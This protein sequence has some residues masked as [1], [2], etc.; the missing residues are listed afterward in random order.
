MR[1][2]KHLIATLVFVGIASLS[3]EYSKADETVVFNAWNFM[4]LS[5]PYTPIGAYCFPMLV[6]KDGKPSRAPEKYEPS[7]SYIP[8]EPTVRDFWK[9]YCSSGKKYDLYYAHP[10]VSSR[11]VSS[12]QKAIIEFSE[13]FKG[14][15]GMSDEE[16][17]IET[18]V[19]AFDID[20]DGKLES[21][22]QY[23]AGDSSQLRIYKFSGKDWT[24]WLEL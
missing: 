19:G 10:N 2:G 13:K 6:I 9:T 12:Q 23:S 3:G 22:T 20:H 16:G 11:S 18:F 7:G 17:P 1:N 24:K 4:H 21:F 8:N 5:N 14:S 15:N